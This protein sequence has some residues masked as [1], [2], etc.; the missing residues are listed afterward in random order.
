V[1]LRY[2]LARDQSLPRDVAW[3]Q[4]WLQS[5]NGLLGKRDLHCC[6]LPWNAGDLERA[7]DGLS[8]AIA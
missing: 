6:A 7:W 5:T 1:I 8:G 3:I 2:G 4:V